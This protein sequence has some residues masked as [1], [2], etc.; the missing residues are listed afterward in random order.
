MK[1]CAMLMTVSLLALGMAACSPSKPAAN[2]SADAASSAAVSETAAAVDDT[3][4]DDV[5]EAPATAA[6]SAAASSVTTVIVQQTGAYDPAVIEDMGRRPGYWEVR[7]TDPGTHKVVIQKVCI[8]RTTGA[9]LTRDGHRVTARRADAA[10]ANWLGAC[11]RDVRAGEV[12]RA[13]GHKIDA[14]N[15]HH[16]QA[17]KPA[18]ATTDRDRNP[19]QDK[20]PNKPGDRAQDG[21]PSRNDNRYDGHAA[22]SAH[23]PHATPAEA[24]SDAPNQ[25]PDRRPDRN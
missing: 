14:W 17:P 8:D 10:S 5:A 3:A 9:Q 16:P 24:N 4:A 20:T 11:P 13:D 6:E 15:G 7:H 22:P 1:S 19:H 21:R 25:H 23:N 18:P 2:A 12:V